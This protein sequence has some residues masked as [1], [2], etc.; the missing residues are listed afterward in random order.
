MIP[1]RG[2]CF[3]KGEDSI[4]RFGHARAFT[5]G[6]IAFDLAR[7]G[8]HVEFTPDDDPKGPRALDIRIMQGFS[9]L[10]EESE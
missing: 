7:E 8:Q 5:D 9:D 1:A 4:S 10:L 3:I 2:F 6:A